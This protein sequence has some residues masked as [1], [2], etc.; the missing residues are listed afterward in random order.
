MKKN[1][2][3][4]ISM[5]L[6]LML[7][8]SVFAF[9]PMTAS[10]ATQITGPLDFVYDI[11]S[12]D[13]GPGWKWVQSS[14]TL[15][16]DGLN[17]VNDEGSEG[18]LIIV[19]DGT[20]IELKNSN[21]IIGNRYGSG[22]RGDGSITF[23][24]SGSLDINVDPEKNYGSSGIVSSGNTIINATGLIKIRAS[25]DGICSFG[26]ITINGGELD[27]DS[28]WSSGIF[29]S[30]NIT[31]NKGN[32]T[33]KCLDVAEPS[34][35]VLAYPLILEKMGELHSFDSGSKI[36]LGENV[37]VKGFDA[38]KNTYSIESAIDNNYLYGDIVASTFVDAGKKTDFL[39]NIQYTTSVLPPNPTPTPT[40]TPKPG[41]KDKKIKTYSVK[42]Y[43]N[44]GKFSGGKITKTYK[45][46][47]N[48][49]LKN[50]KKPQLNKFKFVGW[51]TKPDG[52]KKVDLKNLKVKKNITLYAH[53]QGKGKV[54]TDYP[55]R[56]HLRTGPWKTIIGYHHNTTKVKITGFKGKN[57]YKVNVGGQKGYM[58]K[59]YIKLLPM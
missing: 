47:K 48:K 7:T 58:H 33:I 51:Y 36:T 42:L 56:L 49:K 8:L 4:I 54:K 59:K 30:G 10:A 19:P 43:S 6:V 53:W 35:A 1:R 22:I 32:G 31:F 29:S 28:Y 17:L 44:Y 39:T 40:P 18:G 3:K 5:F 38:N 46:E 25:W 13:N 14:K 57:W 12:D 27:I 23:S 15:T 55:N 9:A 24:G 45:V 21:S 37:T 34:P 50:A 26:N 41:D 2:Q 20:V 11:T 52:G 16:L